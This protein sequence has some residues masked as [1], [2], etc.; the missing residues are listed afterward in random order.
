MQNAEASTAVEAIA[1][2]FAHLVGVQMEMARDKNDGQFY[3][4]GSRDQTWGD[5][6]D[7]DS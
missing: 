3:T 2:P 1:R 5:L 4:W 7:H 6:F